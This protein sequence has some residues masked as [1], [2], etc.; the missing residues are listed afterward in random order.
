MTGPYN[1]YYS[2]YMGIYLGSTFFAGY[3]EEKTD[4][5]DFV[6]TDHGGDRRTEPA[7]PG[8]QGSGFR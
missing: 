2:S 8:L 7:V 6:V 3:Q 4:S 1:F 5:V